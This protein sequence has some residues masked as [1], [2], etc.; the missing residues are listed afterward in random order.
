MIVELVVDGADVDLHVGVRFAQR[1]D[2]LGRADETH[3]FDL[4]RVAL[5]DL[6]DRVDGR[7]AGGKHG[8]EHDHFTLLNIGGKLAVIFH[9]L[10]GLRVAVETDVTDS[11][12]GHKGQH[13]VDHAQ[14]GAQDRHKRQL[15]AG[16]DLGVRH[17]H[18]GFDVTIHQ[19]QVAR[20]FKAHQHGDLADELAELLGSRALVA[21]DGKLVLNKRMIHFMYCHFEHS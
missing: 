11:G 12:V 13:A 15:F 4:L 17:G 3:E 9:G 18:G 8:I 10:E 14:T 1:L 6:G 7:A 19:R 2:A 5:L 20:C 16:D 21:Q